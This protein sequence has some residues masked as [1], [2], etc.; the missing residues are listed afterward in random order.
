MQRGH[1]IALILSGIILFT[2]FGPDDPFW[3]L[4]RS[5]TLVTAPPT[6]ESMGAGLP[7]RGFADALERVTPSVVNIFT[8]KVVRERVRQ[9]LF[10]DPFL[11]RF[12]GDR[13]KVVPRKRLENSLGS[14]V[15]VS[16][17][18]YILTNQ[19]VVAGGTKI[20]VGL[21]D[22]R[23]VDAQLLG[24][25]EKTDLAV[26]KIPVDGLPALAFAD[27][28][29]ARVGD[30]VL[31]VGNPFGVGQTVTMGIVSALGRSL[32]VTE[33]EDFI[34]TDASINPGNSGG[35]LVNARGELLGINT[36][37]YSGKG[38]E[39]SV[40]IGFAIPANMARFVLTGI[41]TG[42]KVS[43]AWLGVLTQKLT[44]R[45][46]RGFGLEGQE[47]VGVLITEVGRKTP[48]DLAGVTPGT[49]ILTFN[50]QPV[51]DPQSLQAMVVQTP[52]GR[53]VDMDVLQDGKRR[54][55]QVVMGELPE[56]E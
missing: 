25:D 28:S 31:A 8:R 45:L 12:F 35:A 54:R 16:P 46:A 21:A 14:G 20:R 49:I 5:V 43:R 26:L 1:V 51:R 2:L 13:L 40:G 48:A 23:E 39:G 24:S 6:E 36:A 55:L 17:E 47:T 27:S 38:G 42:G 29:A 32:G 41:V 50:G 10:G 22:G 7:A 56:S 44:P 37:I 4:R 15:I 53:E 52:I 3:R 33:Y 34:Q 18:G 9:P 30:V 19:H 11:Q